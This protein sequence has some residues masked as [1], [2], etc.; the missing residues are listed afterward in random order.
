MFTGVVCLYIIDLIYISYG[1]SLSYIRSGPTNMQYEMGDTVFCLFSSPASFSTEYGCTE[2][3]EAWIKNTEQDSNKTAC[4]SY[5]HEHV[6]SSDLE[7]VYLPEEWAI[8]TVLSRTWEGMDGS[9]DFLLVKATNEGNQ[10]HGMCSR[11]FVV[12]Q[13]RLLAMAETITK[14]DYDFYVHEVGPKPLDLCL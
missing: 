14:G 3:G 13:D 8:V 11:T 6:S 1:I 4:C 9:G 5:T 2:D 10:F 12:N 7:V